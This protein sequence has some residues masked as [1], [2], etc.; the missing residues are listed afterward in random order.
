ML[1]RNLKLAL[2]RKGTGYQAYRPQARSLVLI[3]TGDGQAILAYGPVALTTRWAMR[4][5]D[6]ID[7]RFMRRFQRLTG[8]FSS[9]L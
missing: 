5:K 3:N 8:L 7:R 1:S 4:L 6:R 2:S 9:F